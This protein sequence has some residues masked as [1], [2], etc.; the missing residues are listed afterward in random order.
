MPMPNINIDEL[1]EKT[2]EAAAE[3][4]DHE[5]INKGGYF[6]CVYFSVETHAPLCIVGHGLSRLGVTAEDMMPSG[7]NHPNLM[8]VRALL[9][10]Y[11]SENINPEDRRVRWLAVVQSNQDQGHRWE[12]AVRTADET[13]PL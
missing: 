13:W 2:R 10:H 7:Y 1:I 12:A 3:H 6:S 8:D 4:P 9:K 11:A 5:M